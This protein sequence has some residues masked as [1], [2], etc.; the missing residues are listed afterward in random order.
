MYNAF[1]SHRTGATRTQVK[2]TWRNR[3]Q[4][5]ET[6]HFPTLPQPTY[7]VQ[8]DCSA[9]YDLENIH[10][11]GSEAENT[12]ALWTAWALL[13]ADHTSTDD[14]VFGAT[15]PPALDQ[16]TVS[17]SPLPVRLTL[18]SNQPIDGVL[19]ETSAV[20]RELKEFRGVN[21]R[22]LRQLGAEGEQACDFQ[23]VLETFR[24]DKISNHKIDPTRPR[25]A[26][27]LHLKCQI[28]LDSLKLLIW[29]DSSILKSDQVQRMMFQFGSLVRQLTNFRSASLKSISN[30]SRE[31]LADI[32][33]WNAHV[34]EA[35][36]ACVH[37]I[38]FTGVASRQPNASAICAWDGELTFQQLD[39]LSARLACLLNRLGVGHGSIIPLC[40][41][42][43]MWTPVAMLGVMR[44]GAASMIFDTSHPKDRLRVIVQQAHAHSQKRLFLSSKLNEGLARE[45]SQDAEVLVV[46]TSVQ[47]ISNTRDWRPVKVKSGDMLYVVFTSGSTGVPK[48]AVINHGNFSSAIR[49]HK[50]PFGFVDSPR[51]LDY[52]SYAFNAVWFNLLH[53]LACGGCVCIP[54][55]EQR[56]GDLAGA[57]RRYNVTYAVMIPTVARLMR[58]QDIPS[59]KRIIFAG[60]KLLWTDLGQWRDMAAVC[61]GYGSA[62]CTVA[63]AVG[64]VDPSTKEDPS[65]GR[66]AGLVTWIVRSD[67]SGLAAI[68][69]VGELWFEGPLVGRGYLGDPDKT[70]EA[71]VENPSWLL[72][73]GPNTP[74]RSGRLYKTGD[75]ARYKTDGTI[76]FM[77]RKD[78]QVKIRGQR[79]QLG[80]VEFHISKCLESQSELPEAKIPVV[81]EV[82]K[83]SGSATPLLIAFLA[84]G[85][86]ANGTK[87]DL[88]ATMTTLRHLIDDSIA[89]HLASYMIPAA[90]FPIQKIPVT[91]TGKTDRRRLRSMIGEI[92]LG[93][94]ADLSPAR[95]DGR[96]QEP[97][98]EVERQ[99]QRLWATI[100]GI[101][102]KTISARDNFFQIGGDSIAAMR[103]VTFAR[104][105]GLS[106]SVADV[107][108]ALSLS[109]LAK[110]SK[111]AVHV[112][113]ITPFSLLD[114][115]RNTQIVKTE[116][117]ARCQ[118]PAEQIL[119]VFPCTQLQQGLL[120]MTAKHSGD[121]LAR[122]VFRL[123]SDADSGRFRRAWKQLTEA[124]DILRTRIVDI[125][126]HGLVQ[127]VTAEGQ[128]LA[129]D[130]ND[131]TRY[132]AEDQHCA[133]GLGSR[134]THA[135]LVADN[136]SGHRYFIWTIHHA[137]YDAWSLPLLLSEIERFYDGSSVPLDVTPFQHFVQLTSTVNQS[138]A[139]EFWRSQLKDCEATQFPPLPTPK[140]QPR[141]DETTTY[142]IAGLRW[143]QSE[144]TTSNL[145]RAAW[146]ILQAGCETT[147][148]VFG[149]VVSGRQ[150]AM[151]GIDR[152]IGPTIATVPLRIKVE[153]NIHVKELQQ[154]IQSQ[155]VAM[156][157]YEQFGLSRIRSLG[158]LESEASDF[159]CLL[160]VQPKQ[161]IKH[162]VEEESALLEEVQEASDLSLNQFSS[163]A[164]A[165]I[166]DLHD[167]G[168]DLAFSFDSKVTSARTVKSMAEKFE[169]I[170][171]RLCE[172]D[173]AVKVSEIV[174]M[175]TA[176]L[177]DI[178]SWNATVPEA[179]EVCVH[180][181]FASVVEKQAGAP[182]VCAWDGNFTY[183]ELDSLSST[184]AHHLV[185]AGVGSGTIVPLCFE[186]SKWT[187]VAM[188]GVMKTGA[189]AVLLDSSHPK[190]QLQ[191]IIRQAHAHSR[192]CLI[193]SS[194]CNSNLSHT[195]AEQG[196]TTTK[197]IVAETATQDPHKTRHEKL[198]KVRPNDMLY[199]VFTS[200]STGEPKG[201]V[202]SHKNFTSAVSHQQA[203]LGL[204]NNSRVFDYVS[205]AFDVAWSNA[206]HALTA[207]GCLCIP[208]PEDRL[209]N[210]AGSLRKLRPTYALLTPTVARLVQASDIPESMRTIVFSGEK[211]T[212]WDTLGWQNVDMMCNAY[213]PAECTVTNT[214]TRVQ[215]GDAGDPSIGKGSG[216]ITWVVRP[217]GLALAA[218]GSVGELWLEGPLVG[219]GYL[220]EP[221]KTAEVFVENPPWL[222]Q[223]AGPRFPGRN[224]RLYRTGDLVRYD[225]DGTLIFVGRK[226]DHVKLRGQ[227]IKL[228]HIE[229]C[230]RQCLNSR[231][232]LAVVV[233]VAY[234]SG[235]TAPLLVAFLALD[236][237]SA[238]GD[239]GSS[240]L[241]DLTL[242]IDQNISD[243]LTPSMI[244]SAYIPVEVIPRTGTGKTDR[245]RLRQIV[246]EMTLEQIA[247]LHR[248]RS[249]EAFQEPSTEIELRLQHLW[250][251]VLN[252]DRQSISA[253]DDFFRIGGDSVGAMRLVA[254]A[255]EEGLSL[256]VIDIFENPSLQKLASIATT[257]RHL[258]RKYAPLSLVRTSLERIST[259]VSQHY[260]SL[261]ILDV[262]LVT[263][264]QRECVQAAA[265]TP[266]GRTYHF[267]LDFPA[268]IRREELV[269]ACHLLWGSFDIL[270]AVFVIEDDQ[271]FQVIPKELPLAVDVH[272][273]QS[274]AD[275]SRR[276]CSIDVDTLHLGKSYVRMA[277]FQSASGHKR[278]ALRL[279]HAQYDGF[280][281]QSMVRFL[282]TILNDG[283][284]P[285]IAPFS[286][287]MQFL[288]DGRQSSVQYWQTLL[289]GSKI[290]RLPCNPAS[291]ATPNQE[292][293][294]KVVLRTP[295]YT[296]S[297]ANTF[298][299]VCAS[300]ISDVLDC[301]DLTLGFLVSGRAMAPHLM[302]VGG[303]C[304]NVAPVRLTLHNDGSDDDTA[305]DRVAQQVHAQRVAGL[306]HEGS[307]FSDIRKAVAGWDRADEGFGFVLQ[308]QNID[309]TPS[310]STAGARS[311][312][313]VHEDY[314]ATDLPF[315]SITARPGEGQWEV[316]L[317]ASAKYYRAESLARLA[318][319]MR[320]VVDGHAVSLAKHDH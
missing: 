133:I 286:D 100:L 2:S 45:L 302:A 39:H 130:G 273:V 259:H 118:V 29:H 290:S 125:M 184:L 278:L 292:V 300:A 155:S 149:A 44:A 106:F 191:K 127:V 35:I 238:A 312:L 173:T 209:D 86:A 75:L 291:N 283:S 159:Q 59:L 317:T 294:Q 126:G 169:G 41:E 160:V 224:G 202:I 88:Q 124:H 214:I 168:L 114:T 274:L 12:A 154:Q 279:C 229:N 94:L 265:A 270:R 67:G 243:L 15:M 175:S 87:T 315:I 25:E 68:G 293:S 89:R 43:S 298:I 27:A 230:L 232:D 156:L 196:G 81:A 70:A 37:D 296:D 218:V 102:R 80:E 236:D 193:V 145:L 26:F 92:T 282:E 56:A 216:T 30:L 172:S 105:Q 289:R 122:Y 210:I 303:P 252:V 305:L 198:P 158:E 137:L 76:E 192:Q 73:G 195:L 132:L 84:I 257:Q 8:L 182:A 241:D 120:A 33:S 170:I 215:A 239:Q 108:R 223:G 251:A 131:L 1:F 260:P 20:Y 18:E 60:E 141:P 157:P 97:K 203:A 174:P 316:T 116:A 152:I 107:F 51:V 266:L 121:Y 225:P 74:G 147:D 111:D 123:R 162:G 249:Q 248:N 135:A 5:L 240:T 38:I 99:L 247:S 190:A 71:F 179:Y 271:Y 185:S 306:A 83:P 313:Q 117:A 276:W 113:S 165:V 233:E 222:T 221:Q 220:G 96:F 297:A 307:Q 319:A 208:S 36:D 295:T 308:Y 112:E 177:T 309:E 78:D 110:A 28:Q 299:A 98:T 153:Q 53:T 207:G 213:G 54:S 231:P 47:E 85:P 263:D 150:A 3:L 262:L 14:V 77:G 22:W 253:T 140:Y 72:R 164:L 205:Y 134:L 264:F 32:W 90:Y 167:D 16:P 142:A 144:I 50:I 211:L 136:Q 148:V 103:L 79:V 11:L 269:T 197:I 163:Y 171:R 212:R 95:S 138:A 267:F 287:Y 188:L 24:L 82:G 250:S 17:A 34:P 206:L 58:H 49:H 63:G 4:G 284:R 151:P 69:T 304:V 166:C 234:P 10:L 65:I 219:R 244:P 42:K 258:A 139:A 178:W 180:E 161:D 101:D 245:R 176:D 281:L 261:E 183:H 189:A 194:Q 246:S 7:K 9:N 268:E 242:L 277:V 201:A 61:N 55:D 311:T 285:T 62:E 21:R 57:I 129:V 256:S 66:G 314:V 91:G 46:E 93:Q 272:T 254:A 128:P 6:S 146:A 115:G 280:M 275:A 109:E 227:L 204:S 52:A 13:I 217:D 320:S 200:G 31:D 228:G 143:P 255:S 235:S 119:D 288:E 199:V 23:S 181:L 318:R 104:D 310:F 186:K 301:R 40:F 64:D 48:G 187:P 19:K 226:D 237:T